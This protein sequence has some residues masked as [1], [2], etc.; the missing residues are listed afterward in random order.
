MIPLT[1]TNFTDR[2]ILLGQFWIPNPYLKISTSAHIHSTSVLEMPSF[3]I[4]LELQSSVIPF[5]NNV[6]PAYFSNTLILLYTPV[7]M[8]KQ[9]S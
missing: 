5:L 6:M 8:E 3:R 4:T 1:T 7:T 2:Q 9:N